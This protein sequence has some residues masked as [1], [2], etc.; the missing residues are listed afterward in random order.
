MYMRRRTKDLGELL[1]GFHAI[2]RRLLAG[3]PAATR[4]FRITGS[5]W[6]GLSIIARKGSISIKDLGADLGI[7]SSAATQIVGELVKGGYV[8]KRPDVHD[9]RAAR[10]ALSPKT[11]KA[12]GALR[13]G[14]LRRMAELFSV[15]DDA[16][17]ALY[18]KLQ[19]KLVRPDK[20]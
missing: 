16:E 15:L 7:T 12:L 11:K 4:S 13:R 14:A 9:A 8:T 6:L 17:F 2:K 10:V 18:V 20:R 19:S 1:E 5:Q 3:E